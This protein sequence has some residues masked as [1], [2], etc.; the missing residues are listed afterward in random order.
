VHDID[1][2]RPFIY[3]T[4]T[5]TDSLARSNPAVKSFTYRVISDDS[6]DNKVT[7][8]E[9]TTVH[10]KVSLTNYYEFTLDWTPFSID[11]GRVLNY[12]IYRSQNGGAYTLINTLDP[13]S[14]T[15][16][17]DVSGIVE[18]GAQYCYKVAAKYKLSLP[19]AFVLNSRSFSNQA[20]VVHRPIVFIPNA[21]A[22]DGT[23]RI[24]KPSIVFNDLNGYSMQIFN[25]WG[26]EVFESQDYDT[27]WN[28]SMNGRDAPAGGYAYLI[29]FNG[30]DGLTNEYKGIVLLVR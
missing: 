23:N 7:S 3:E 12:E 13:N 1:V 11:Y 26:E 22:P 20:C 17:D 6:C 25:R 18:D 27:G 14:Y 30:L 28:G 21:F 29:R 10:L 9:A 24:F 8:T 16:I 5:L 4:D 15:Y 2:T 19:N